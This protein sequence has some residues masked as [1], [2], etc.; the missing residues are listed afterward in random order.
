MAF[1]I[2]FHE[3]KCIGCGACSAVCPD[4]WEL[5][6][7]KAHP[8]VTNLEEKGCNADAQ[9]ICPTGAIEIVEE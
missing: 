4:N 7:D 2:I 1:K 9:D 3:D 5:N 6:G 8:K